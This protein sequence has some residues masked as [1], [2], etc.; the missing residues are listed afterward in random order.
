MAESAGAEDGDGGSQRCNGEEKGSCG[1]SAPAG[2]ARSRW[3]STWRPREVTQWRTS[4]AA[5]MAAG[6]D[7]GSSAGAP[8]GGS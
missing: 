2:S 3:W 8:G 4:S 5:E 7:G 6:T 1:T